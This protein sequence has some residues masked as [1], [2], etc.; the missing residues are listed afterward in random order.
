MNDLKKFM[1]IPGNI[2]N[3]ACNGIESVYNGI[4][5][6]ISNAGKTIG[7]IIGNLF[8]ETRNVRG[9]DIPSLLPDF[10]IDVPGLIQN[11][12]SFQFTN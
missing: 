7:N 2:L 8:G 5:N 9:C 4:Y 10:D 6:G 3:K 1:D 11:V 12:Q